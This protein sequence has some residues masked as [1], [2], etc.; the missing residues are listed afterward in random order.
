MYWVQTTIER[1]DVH[2]SEIA[3]PA[4]TICPTHLSIRNFNESNQRH[5]ELNRLNKLF[6]LVAGIQWNTLAVDQ[7]TE[8]DIKEFR[9]FYNQS[10]SDIGNILN[11]DY[12]CEDLFMQCMWRRRVVD[13]CSFFRR[14]SFGISCFT[15]NSMY[16]TNAD[17]TW[18]WS[19]AGSN[20]NSGL[21]VKLNR[22]IG[23][24]RLETVG[25]SL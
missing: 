7:I 19:V 14:F 1:T 20:F 13:C 16:A 21:N 17:R 11:H 10:L 25:V 5:I 18:P 23:E 2:V 4:I 6:N 3:F 24:N 12:K 9:D 8:E 22:F 15:F